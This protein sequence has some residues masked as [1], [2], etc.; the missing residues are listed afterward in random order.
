[1]N[2][3]KENFINPIDKDSITETPS[4]LPYAHERGGQLIKPIDKGRLK[5][6]ALAAMYE[7]SDMQLGQIREQIELLAK[8]AQAIH[9]RVNI[10]ERIYQADMSIKPLVG[11]TYYLYKRQKGQEMLSLVAPQE[12]GKN[13]TLE[14]VASVKLL[15]DHTWEILNDE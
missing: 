15:A 11:R 4:T 8:Q 10:S 1:M 13:S 5:G 2:K 7:Q 6:N 12:W 9:D 14:F 3:E